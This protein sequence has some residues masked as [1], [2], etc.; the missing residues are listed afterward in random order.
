MN[1][2]WQRFLASL[3]PGVRVVLF[4]WLAGGLAAIIGQ[5]FHLFDLHR[6]LDLSGPGFWHGQV[7][8]LVTYALLPMGIM[9]LIM[10][11]I[12]LVILGGMIERHWT[13]GQFWVYC[14]VAAAGAGLAKVLLQWT[15]PIALSGATPLV[16]GLLI[17][18]GFLSGREIIMLF[19][20]GETTVCKLV[21]IAGAISFLT[22][23]FTGGLIMALIMAAGGVTGFIYLWLKHQWLM[24]RA[25]SVVP[26]E[27][28]HRLEL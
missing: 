13:R 22:M 5:L 21:L 28:I 11:S 4:L 23:F 8:R 26:S 17:A 25:G 15:S 7:W 1:R 16:F 2:F 20:F 19:F 9:D 10:N 12:A 18:W 14:L 3:T 24:N 6:W 27:R